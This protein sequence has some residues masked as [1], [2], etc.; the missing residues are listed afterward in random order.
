M[1]VLLLL[2]ADQV[3]RFVRQYTYIGYWAKFQVTYFL[4]LEAMCHVGRVITYKS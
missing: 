4:V 3:L 2:L 1:I